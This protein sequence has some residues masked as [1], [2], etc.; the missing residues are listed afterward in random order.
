MGEGKGVTAMSN[1][2][3]VPLNSLYVDARP[4]AGFLVDLEPGRRQGM[5]KE[6]PGYADVVNE[7]MA[8][9]REYGEQAGITQTQYERFVELNRQ[10]ALID[11][12]LPAMQ[13]LLETMIETRAALDDER[14]GLAF[15]FAVSVERSAKSSRDAKLLAKYEK[16]RAYRSSRGNKAAKT[17]QKNAAAAAQANANTDTETAS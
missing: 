13:K 14:Q 17:R 5:R 11:E 15:G 1:P 16:T 12:R 8:N 10:I 6:Q 2:S 7:I 4:L 3:K 9:Q